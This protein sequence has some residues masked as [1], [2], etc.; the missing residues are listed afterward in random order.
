MLLRHESLASHLNKT[1][2]PL[3]VL[4]SDEQL[5][6]LETVDMIRQAVRR[7]NVSERE[8]MT[9][10]EHGFKWEQLHTANHSFSL[11]GDRKLI[12]LRIPNGKPGKEGS[13]TLQEYVSELNPDN[14]TLI[15]LP[16]LDWTAQ[17]SAW[18]NTLQKNG[19][20]IEIPSIDVS[21]LGVW[22]TSRLR[23]QNQTVTPSC[24]DFLVK[25][26]EGN[27]LAAHQEIQKLGLLYPEGTLN[28]EQVSHSV[29]NVARYDI[30]KLNEAIL[31]G[32]RSRFI[33]MMEGLKGEGTA[34]E[35]L[36]WV[37][38]EEI[39]TLL[40]CKI[41]F[42]KGQSFPNIVKTFRLKRQ[43]EKLIFSAINRLEKKTLQKAL[44]QTAQIDR[45]N[46][47]LR[48]DFWMDDAWDAMTQLGLS[49]VQT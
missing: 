21:Q 37:L 39:R 3:Y 32:N 42:E 45:I 10:G 20:Y 17:K 26:V 1:L 15:T 28:F 31:S 49:L 16:K 6:L 30:F 40:K 12:E 33:R 34:P 29:L 41:A 19:I 36:L 13:Q 2:A 35:L 18:I 5:L 22:I 23:K 43:Q 47:G 46:K 25:H 9:A 4:T 7:N 11:F 38:T 27:L 14:I 48:S 8:I 24:I 44:Q